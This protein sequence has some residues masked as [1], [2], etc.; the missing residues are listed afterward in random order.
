MMIFLFFFFEV[1]FH[2]WFYFICS[3]NFPVIGYEC[4]VVRLVKTARLQA[5]FMTE[6]GFLGRNWSF[7]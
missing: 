3:V 5:Q 6:S 7:R 2:A 1:D 4:E